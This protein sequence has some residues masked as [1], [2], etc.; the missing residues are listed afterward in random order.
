L[1][2]RRAENSKNSANELEQ[3]LIDLGST[4]LMT[5]AD[6][7]SAQLAISGMLSISDLQALSVS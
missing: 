6:F 2:P 5:T 4:F 7:I 3:T 1:T